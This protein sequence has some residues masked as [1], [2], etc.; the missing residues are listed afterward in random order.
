[1][2]ELLTPLEVP[3][4]GLSFRKNYPEFVFRIERSIPEEAKLRRKPDNEHDPNAIAVYFRGKQVG[5]VSANMA[6][7]L[8]PLMDQ[9]QRFRAWFS[10]VTVHPDHPDNPGLWV[11]VDRLQ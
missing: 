4:A 6:K 11:M 7:H 10:Q 8:A 2:T 1:M 5:W 3:V 9:G